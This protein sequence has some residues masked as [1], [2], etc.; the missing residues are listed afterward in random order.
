MI[1]QLI[2]KIKISKLRSRYV[3]MH[4]FSFVSIQSIVDIDAEQ[5]FITKLMI[6]D[7]V[8]IYRVGYFCV[9]VTV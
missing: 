8:Q 5:V 9:N 7:Y 6:A 1:S 3:D 2:I 4:V